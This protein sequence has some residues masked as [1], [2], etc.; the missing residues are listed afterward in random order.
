MD[1]NLKLVESLLES[2]IKYGL[3]EVELVKLKTFGQVDGCGVGFY[4]AHRC[5]HY[6]CIVSDLF[7]FWPCILAWQHFRE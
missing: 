2:T 6:P 1:N 7:Q 4:P 5:L 3:A